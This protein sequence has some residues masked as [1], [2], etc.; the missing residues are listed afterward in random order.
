MI[1]LQKKAGEEF[2]ELIENIIKDKVTP[3]QKQWA[4]NTLEDIRRDLLRDDTGLEDLD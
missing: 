2:K 1:N 3:E 4:K